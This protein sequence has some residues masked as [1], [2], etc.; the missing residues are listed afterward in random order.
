M[1][2][3]S[4]ISPDVTTWTVGLMENGTGTS[5]VRVVIVDDQAL[6]RSGLARLL[7]ADSRVEVVGEAIDGLD[8]IRVCASATPDVVLMDLKMPTLGGA[9]ATQRILGAHPKVRVLILS[10]FDAD[11]YVLAALKAGAA[12]YVLKDSTP[13]A[14]ISSILAVHAGERVMAGAVANRVLEMISGNAT[15]KE[16]YDGLTARETEILRMIATG[17]PNKQIAFRLG[18]SEKTV[19]NHVS[20]MYEKL[21]IYDRSQAVLYAARK[22]LVEL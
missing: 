12:G 5:R 3:A 14:I 8:A 19:R 18:I 11:S 6:F 13:E 10:T 17:A 7:S 1:R 20:N 4:F 9:E 22:G 21:N 15:P 16:F 2:C